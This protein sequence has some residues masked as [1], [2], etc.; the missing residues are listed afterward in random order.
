MV[1][2]AALEF[3]YEVGCRAR[4]GHDGTAKFTDASFKCIACIKECDLIAMLFDKCMDF[5]RFQVDTATDNTGFINNEFLGNTECNDFFAHTN[6]ESREVFANAVRPFP[7]D[8]V[9]AWIF[10]SDATVTLYRFE[11]SADGSV[12][13]I[14]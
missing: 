5:V 7:I 9:K 1:V 2:L 6:S 8:V 4:I 12:N 14:L 10:T 3:P 13:A 11:F